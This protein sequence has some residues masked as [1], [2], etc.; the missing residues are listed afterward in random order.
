MFAEQLASILDP[1]EGP[2]R[3]AAVR[4]RSSER[5]SSSAGR[6]GGGGGSFTPQRNFREESFVVR[7]LT[8]LDG[9]PEARIMSRHDFSV[10]IRAHVPNTYGGLH[11]VV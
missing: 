5:S 11:D 9:I 8:D 7:L 4:E 3:W 1:P 2:S 6:V 10:R